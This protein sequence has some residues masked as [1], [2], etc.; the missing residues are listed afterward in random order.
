MSCDQLSAG[1]ADHQDALGRQSRRRPHGV[2]HFRIGTDAVFVCLDNPDQ[3]SLSLFSLISL[4]PASRV[5]LSSSP[6]PSPSSPPPHSSPSPS[7]RSSSSSTASCAHRRRR[8]PLV[9]SSSQNVVH[10]AAP[11][12]S[13][14]LLSISLSFLST[15]CYYAVAV[16]S[17][18]LM[19]L[20]PC[21]DTTLARITPASPVPC[22]AMLGA[23]TTAM[24][25]A[26]PCTPIPLI[27]RPRKPTHPTTRIASHRTRIIYLPYMYHLVA[28]SVSYL[29]A[30]LE[31]LS[32]ARCYRW[33][34]HRTCFPR[35]VFLS[36]ESRP[37]ARPARVRA[38]FLVIYILCTLARRYRGIY[39]SLAGTVLEIPLD[40]PH[41]LR[42]A[43]SSSCLIPPLALLVSS[44]PSQL[45]SR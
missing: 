6:S 9:H 5:S 38:Y 45:T 10:R 29:F 2:E 1:G 42:G 16:R 31:G 14:S 7:A 20:L 44:L 39:R 12:W 35:V 8:R 19:W 3:S 37:R 21:L 25:P 13:V 28:S 30:L 26:T 23:S 32:I 15:V 4:P 36:L 41:Q 40:G 27:P 22:F 43:P 24:H 34:T 17:P 18:P 11:S 33:H